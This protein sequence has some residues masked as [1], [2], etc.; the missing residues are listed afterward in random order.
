MGL[1][2]SLFEAATGGSKISGPEFAEQ[3]NNPN[4]WHEVYEAPSCCWVRKLPAGIQILDA[5]KDFAPVF[6]TD[7]R[8]RVLLQD[9]TAM[10]LYEENTINAF[11]H[12]TYGDWEK[13]FVKIKLYLNRDKK[14]CIQVPKHITDIY[15]TGSFG[16]K[17]YANDPMT[18]DHGSG[19]FLV[20]S[21]PSPEAFYIANGADFYKRYDCTSFGHTFKEKYPSKPDGFFYKES[22][23]LFSIAGHT[24]PISDIRH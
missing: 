10:V 13:D 18:G 12:D 20:S 22:P 1:L 21:R 15:V 23:R 17:T 11:K 3:M 2:G 16:H 14:Y 7:A 19:D 6:E 9:E 5:D 4:N 8:H 24:G